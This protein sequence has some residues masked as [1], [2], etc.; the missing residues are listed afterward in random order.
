MMNEELLIEVEAENQAGVNQL[1]YKVWE[2]RLIEAWQHFENAGFKPILIKGW[3]AAQFYPE[4]SERQFVDI[5]LMFEPLEFPAAE[6]FIAKGGLNILVD[7]HRGARHLDELSFKKLFEN[8]VQKKCGETQIRVPSDEDHLRILCVHWLNDGGTDRKRL[9]DIYFAVTNRK[10]NFDWDKCLNAVSQKRR[11]WVVCAMV[12]ANKYLDLSLGGI[13]LS[14]KDRELPHWLVKTVEQ[15]WASG[16][17]LKPLHSVLTQKTELRQQLEKRFLPNP[18]QAT[19][20]VGG[21]F[22]NKP[23]FIYQLRDIL[24]RALPSLKRISKL[25]WTRLR[26][27]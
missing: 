24:K 19:I 7:L 25:Y 26:Q 18:I 17:R 16:I 8:S 21:V 13:P 1:Y 10:E 20:E 12:L 6:E 11:R 2:H 27:K 3:A 4:P 14:Q 5:D 9:E 23:R 15:E 22:D